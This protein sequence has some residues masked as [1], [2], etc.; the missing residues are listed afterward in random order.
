MF[1]VVRISALEHGLRTAVEDLSR[2]GKNKENQSE[3]F[4]LETS[5]CLGLIVSSDQ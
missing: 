2:A 3:G 4:L 1:H 5:A